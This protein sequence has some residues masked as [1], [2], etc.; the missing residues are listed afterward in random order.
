MAFSFARLFSVGN[1]LKPQFLWMFTHQRW[2]FALTRLGCNGWFKWCL[3]SYWKKEE[4]NM[5]IYPLKS[6]W[7]A[8]DTIDKLVII[9][10]C[11]KLMKIDDYLLIWKIT[12]VSVSRNPMDISLALTKTFGA[13]IQNDSKCLSWQS[14]SISCLKYMFI[15]QSV[16]RI[17]QA[18]VNLSTGREA[19][20]SHLWHLKCSQSLI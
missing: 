13:F 16:T 6:T 10:F 14:K 18:S 19:L 12:V 1:I 9:S 15:Q 2:H 4:I 8:N 11:N 5:I 17:V 7:P 3:Q 20:L